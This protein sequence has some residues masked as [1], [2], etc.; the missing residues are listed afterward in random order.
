MYV[1]SRWSETLVL[2]LKRPSIKRI[3]KLELKR[4]NKKLELKRRNKRSGGR[5]LK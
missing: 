5:R 4:R 1:R 2:K 3:E